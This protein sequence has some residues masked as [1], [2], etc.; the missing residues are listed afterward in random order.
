MRK[1]VFMAAS[2][3]VILYSLVASTEEAQAAKAKQNCYDHTTYLMVKADELNRRNV[4][5][6]LYQLTQDSAKTDLYF[7]ILLNESNLSSDL[8]LQH[9]NICGMRDWEKNREYFVALTSNKYCVYKH[10]RYS[11]QDLVKYM[12]YYGKRAWYFRFKNQLAR[13]NTNLEK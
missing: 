4:Y 2:A 11:V 9:H 13:I 10:W 8:A 12:D 6:Y 7:R 1:L 3:L 5:E